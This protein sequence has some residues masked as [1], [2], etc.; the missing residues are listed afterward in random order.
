MVLTHLEAA[1][2]SRGPGDS[3]VIIC[4]STKGHLHCGLWEV[5][6]PL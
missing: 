2:V 4:H 5:E 6:A 1:M 3:P